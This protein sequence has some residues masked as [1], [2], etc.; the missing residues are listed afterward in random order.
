MTIQPALRAP[1]TSDFPQRSP[2]QKRRAK[3]C[4][5][6]EPISWSRSC[7]ADRRQDYEI[8]QSGA[9]DLL[10]TG[11]DH[12]LFVNYNE[13]VAAVESSYDAHYVTAVDVTINVR[14]QNGR[15]STTWWPQFRIID[16][17]TVAPDPEVLAVV[18]GLR[19]ATHQEMD[20][21]LGTTEV[22]LDSRNATVRAREGRIG[23]VI[24]DAVRTSLRR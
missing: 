12:D 2:R 14:E 23:N 8:M 11:H 24:A 4:A 16:T 5:A 18:A 3:R 7:T 17:A 9:V 13:R 1:E 22:E 15:R 6:K 20:V 19:G 21:P 10:L